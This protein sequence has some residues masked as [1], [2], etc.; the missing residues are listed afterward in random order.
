MAN[1][2]CI[3]LLIVFLCGCASTPEPPPPIPPTKIHLQI[4]AGNAI[5]LDLAGKGAPLLMRIYELREESN[6]NGTDFYALFDKEKAVLAND[7]VRKQEFLLKPGDSK[8]LDFEPATDTRYLAAFAAFR[9][10]DNAQWR[11]IQSL[12]LHQ[13]NVLKINIDNNVLA[14]ILEKNAGQ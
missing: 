1:L 3:L 13:D 14:I 6:F 9:Q 4:N 8:M 5:N 11:Q 10:L 2:A 7:L 12:T